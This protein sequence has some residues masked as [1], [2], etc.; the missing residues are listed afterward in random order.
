MPDKVIDPAMPTAEDE[1]SLHARVISD[2]TPAW[3]TDALDARKTELAAL[4]LRIP[5]WYKQASAPDRERMKEVHERSRRSLNQLDQMFCQLKSPT[6]Y[7]EPLLVAEIEK[8]FGQRL[9]VRQLFYTRKV[10]QPE[11]NPSSEYVSPGKVS[12]LAPQFYLYKGLSLLEAALNNFTEDEAIPPVCPDCR[13]ITRYDFH[14]YSASKQH[15]SARVRTLKLGIDAYVFAAMCRKLDLGRSYFEHVRGAL[16]A[17]ISP[18]VTG[19][20][21]GKLYSTL[22]T[23]HRNQ[24]EL[25][26]EI[27]L[28][29]GDIQPPQH[30]LIKAILINQTGQKWGDDDVSFSRFKLYAFELENILI[31][32]PV[33]RQDYLV[34]SEILP[35][36]C[37]VYIP[38]DPLH[39]LKTYDNVGAF[40]DQLTTR[41]CAVE[42]RQFFSQFIPISQQ[43]GF[44]SKLKTLLDPDQAYTFDQD[45][46]AAKKGKILTQGHYGK[47]WGDLWMDSALQRIRLIMAN[48]SAS[49]VSTQDITERAYSA[50]LWSWGSKALDVL[51]V[52]AFVVPFLGE[53]M[54]VVCAVQMAYE[55]YEGLGALSDGDTGAA[56][57]HFSAVALNLAGLAVPKLLLAAKDTAIVRRL[58]HVQFGGRT[59]LYAFNPAHYRHQVTLPKDLKPD[60]SGLYA[61]EGRTYLPVE[62]GHYQV[63]ATPTRNDFRL[64]HPD[65][66]SRYAPS[67][68]HNGE[69]AWVHEFERPLTWNRSKL[70]RRLG[71]RVEHLSDSQLEQIR[72]ISG[73]SDDQLRRV[74]VD[75][76][77]P[78][79]L[80]RD[81]LRRFECAARYQ[82]FIDRLS[83]ADLQTFS[84]A[85]WAQQMKVMMA[86]GMWPTSRVLVVFDA[87]DNLVWRSAQVKT[88]AQVVKLDEPQIES[89]GLFPSL[90]NQL[91]ESEIRHLLDE[92]SL[93][94]SMRWRLAMTGG[95]ELDDTVLLRPASPEAL[96]T[97]AE[98]LVQAQR[99]PEA[100]ALQYR[101][102]LLK[103]A[104][105]MR[106]KLINDEVVAGDLSSEPPVQLIQRRFPGL[107]KLVAQELV[108][109]ANSRELK[110]ME[111]T[112]R[113]PLRLA[114][115]ARGYLQKARIMRAYTDLLFDNELSMD[116]VRLALHKLAALPDRLEGLGIELR[117]GTYDGAVLD[118]IG[119]ADA[120]RQCRLVRISMKEWAVYSGP[121]TVEYWRSD[122]DAFYGALWIASKGRFTDLS[123]LRVA[124]QALKTEIAA[125]PLSEPASRQALGLQAIKPGFKSPM[126]LSDGRL[127]YPLSPI[128]GADGGA[129]LCEMKAQLLY[130]SKTFAETVEMLGLQER[131]EAVLLARLNQL[132]E[133]FTQLNEELRDWQQGGDSGYRSARR[134]VSVSITRAW[135]R[136]T[137]QAYAADQTPIGY[138]LDL[139]QEVIDE[140]PALSANM[141]HVGHLVLQ[142]MSLSD[143]S[144]P[145]LRSFGGLRWLNMR[146]NNLTRLP[147]FANGGA[148]LTKLDLSRNDIQLT[149]PTRVRLEAM[150]NL[151]ILDLSNNRRLGW[152]ANLRGMRSLNQLYL[153]DTGTTAFPAGAEQLPNL[154]MINLHT[155]RITTLP[156]YAYQH[157]DRINVHDNPLSAATL[158]R[159][160]GEDGLN[161]AEWDDHVT[162]AQARQAWLRD[163]SPEMRTQRGELWD[164][165]L[166]EPEST[167]LF[168]VLADTTR[169]AE[170][171]SEV[172]RAALAER[173][174]DMLEATRESQGI[175]ETLFSTAD[176]RVTC[177]DGSTVE[178]MNLERA[179]IGARA[180]AQAGEANAEGA[181]IGTA[182]KL[183]RLHL[184]DALAQRDVNARGPGFTEQVEVILAY[185]IKLADRLG[186][187]VKTRDMLFPHQAN[188]SEAAID[189]AY[190]QVLRDERVAADETAFFVD[191]DFWQKHLRTRYAQEIEASM[192]PARAQLT[193]KVDALEDL[194]E[195]QARQGD[196]ADQEQW[197]AHRDELVNT[198][199]RLL[200]K[201][202]DEILVNGSMQSAFYVEQYAALGVEQQALDKQVMG[203]LTRSVL[204]NFAAEQ[205]T[206]I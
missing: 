176:D 6:D 29:K 113:L 18:Q 122:P 147:E 136:E 187:P 129:R 144:L 24:L 192:A 151:K 36:P 25:A 58:V 49:A 62:D 75:Q 126:R 146:E 167:S 181:L 4:N 121:K 204:N 83:S 2:N 156:G 158:A 194:S 189:A 106:G 66:D 175:R 118:R 104:K 69:G 47:R 95:L 86:T 171:A 13:L 152:T 42:Y 35:R 55:V 96:E 5:D 188:V 70:L 123:R 131:G 107:P 52:A 99:T 77:L 125:Q 140:L 12:P 38:G 112:S 74:Y 174:W 53:V 128:G 182:R 15:F 120:P 43:D 114:E 173:V 199:G 148:R 27:A 193:A 20:Q 79:P 92:A 178:F 196:S 183:F 110:Y 54:L 141:D 116:S 186:L 17:H 41:L 185:R 197:R 73:V 160:R 154:A 45:F 21:S 44:Y 177:G 101:E 145:F 14:Q 163:V 22:I 205:G 19:A 108:E 184:V 16:N 63:Q 119:H 172:T 64:I 85:D 34:N 7:A 72:L 105:Q 30:A 162:M 135:Q 203:T 80:F 200:G 59:R 46:D 161:L 11:C 33:V 81:A 169:S 138:V 56:W 168:T 150:Q 31:I 10:E 198:L 23:S 78:P 50:W 164:D 65:G 111:D 179:L 28:M 166:A 67:I 26:A 57:E 94:R 149:E 91:S 124:A 109:H 97:Q 132:H 32:G 82:A 133:E 90:L 202:R 68:R 155:N 170:Y 130:P 102:R 190:E 165:V 159:I 153:Q 60:T 100:R 143:R 117:E 139:R 37:M 40:T 103:A 191:Q 88:R 195:W 1:Q 206:E 115:E 61:H 87:E 3:Y 71:P 180:A 142:R 93:K 76:Q 98:Q 8:T 201:P 84:R 137:S 51:N 39:P 48:A 134:T 9:D 127:G 89:S 157:P